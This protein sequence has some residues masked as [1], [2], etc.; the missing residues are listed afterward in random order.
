MFKYEEISLFTLKV[1]KDSFISTAITN[2][3]HCL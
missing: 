2:I 3:L 1:D